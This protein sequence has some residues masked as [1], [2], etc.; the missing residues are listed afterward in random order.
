MARAKST[1]HFEPGTRVAVAPARRWATTS[2][3]AE[4]LGCGERTVRR[5]IAS[6]HIRA[7]RVNARLLR[8]DLNEADDAIAA[9]CIPSAATP[10]KTG[11]V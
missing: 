9:R 3:T 5:M 11:R 8:I 4:Y 2:E 7:Y 10:A 6:G 1:T